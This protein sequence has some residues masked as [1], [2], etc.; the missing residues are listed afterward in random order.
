MIDLFV[1][2]AEWHHLSY[3]TGGICHSETTYKKNKHT[4]PRGG[5]TAKCVSL[6]LNL[7]HGSLLG[8]CI[9]EFELPV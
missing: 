4:K 6:D 5:Q 7:C 3:H 1:S 9:L 8:F 2:H